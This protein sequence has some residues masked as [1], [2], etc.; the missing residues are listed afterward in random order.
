[1][2]GARH[3]DEGE[4]FCLSISRLRTIEKGRSRGIKLSIMDGFSRRLHTR[5]I[6][7]DLGMQ[8][9]DPWAAE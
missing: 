7:Q 8:L 2:I 1:L 5:G 6:F 9:F 4:E 3:H